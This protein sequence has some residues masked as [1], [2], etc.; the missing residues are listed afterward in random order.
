[1]Y[2]WHGL[3][4]QFWSVGPACCRNLIE[5]IIDGMDQ[6]CLVDHE[7]RPNEYTYA[8]MWA[9]YFPQRTWEVIHNKSCL[10]WHDPLSTFFQIGEIQYKM[11]PC[12]WLD[13]EHK[14]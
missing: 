6:N 11:P 8:M 10:I 1:M 12:K 5:D 7:N 14:L 9:T 4:D 2:W 3:S 13:A